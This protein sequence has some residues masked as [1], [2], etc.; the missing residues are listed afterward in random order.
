MVTIAINFLAGRF[1]ATPWDRHVNE[2]VVE[3]P[4][5][6]WRLLRSLIAVGFRKLGWDPTNPPDDARTLVNSLSESPPHFWLP[7]AATAHTRH[8]M[9]K[10]RSPLDRKTD[11]VLDAFV[12]VDPDSPVIIHWPD[13]ELDAG[14][15]G[16]LEDLLTNL[17]YLGR[18]E[19]WVQA[20]FTD[21][22]LGTPNSLPAD[23]GGD[24]G[25]GERT[26]LLAPMPSAKYLTWREQWIQA[27]TRKLLDE[28]K[29][30]PSIKDPAK[31]RLSPKELSKLEAQAGKELFDAMMADTGDLQSAG[32]N[33]PPGSRWVDYLRPVNCFTLKPLRKQTARKAIPTVAKFALTAESVHADVRPRLL[34]TL[35]IADNMRKALMSLSAR[36][37]DGMPS[38]TFSG[39]DEDGRPLKGHRHAFFLPL[40]DDEDGR[41]EGIILYAPKGFSDLDQLALARLRK[42]WQHG[43]RPGLYPVLVGIGQPDDFGGLDSGK[44]LTPVLA[45]GR[46]WESR[47]PF[48]L[49]RHP[50]RRRNGEPKVN[51]DGTWVDGPDDQ[52][53]KELAQRALPQP[54]RVEWVGYTKSRGKKLY[55]NGFAKLRTG[56]HGSFAGGAYGFRLTFSESVSGP[57][58]LGYGC[59][60]GLGQFR[61]ID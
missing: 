60:Y 16:L 31:I 20:R 56:G 59:H 13:I 45:K 49:T 22:W 28:K 30:K 12:V 46:V 42:L 11:K 4:I 40:D 14:G 47:T 35:Y 27:Q 26:K 37:N 21:Q 43:G 52:L 15:K 36:E 32:W 24:T 8:Y 51:S 34:D 9:P 54:E 53:R 25:V 3:W 41:I 10:Y 1:H 2:G 5:S 33:Y 50:K 7:P 61:A 48:V 55:W 29:H 44:K 18:E 6:S 39:K 57:I 38:I 23:V 58:A 17:T 19:S